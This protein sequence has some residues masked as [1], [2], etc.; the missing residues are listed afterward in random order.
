M[1]DVIREITLPSKFL[2]QLVIGDI[3]IEQV[4]GI[5]NAANEHLIHGGGIA[6][7]IEKVGGEV[8]RK[9]SQAWIQRNGPITHAKPAFTNSGNL[10]CKYV[11]HAVGPVWG[12]GD[13]DSKLNDAIWGSLRLGDRL[14]LKS[15]AFPAISTGIFRFPPR[16]AAGV[17]Y[18]AI[19][20]YCHESINKSIEHIRMVIYT[21]PNIQDFQ[22]VWDEMFG[23]MS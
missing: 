3:T 1:N 18:T 10:P 15:I 12:S 7:V 9:E 19:E 21:Q 8:I 22:E 14:R 17:I 16:R 2:F 20:N 13:E 5:V 4:D 23:E 6:A 11:I